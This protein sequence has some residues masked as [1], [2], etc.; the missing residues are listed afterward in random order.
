MILLVFCQFIGTFARPAV[1]GPDVLPNISP[2]P[3]PVPVDGGA[4]QFEFNG[5]TDTA[6]VIL[7]QEPPKIT[8]NSLASTIQ[9][10]HMIELA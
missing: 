9:V 10:S 1:R 2:S 4:P 5:L 3:L 6:K 7:T 8:M